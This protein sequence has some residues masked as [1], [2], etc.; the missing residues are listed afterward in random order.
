MGK[1]KWNPKGKKTNN[2]HGK[3]DTPKKEFKF[4]LPGKNGGEKKSHATFDDIKKVIISKVANYEKGGTRMKKAIFDMQEPTFTVPVLAQP[5]TP[6]PNVPIGGWKVQADF[7]NNCQ[8]TQKRAEEVN[9]L[10]KDHEEEKKKNEKAELEYT[11]CCSRAFTMITTY[12]V[13]ERLMT[14]IEGVTDFDTRIRDNPVELLK[15]VRKFI[16]ETDRLQSPYLVGID[17][18]ARTFNVRQTPDET[19]IEYLS[20]IHI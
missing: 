5:K 10:D 13:T 11:D 14:K 2:N 15:E 3:S 7:N 12:H 6:I 4:D 18:L 20:L 16:T 9:R 8:Q 19:L 1:G 17:I